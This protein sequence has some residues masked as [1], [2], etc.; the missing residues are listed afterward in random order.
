MSID[1]APFAYPVLRDDSAREAQ[2][3]ARVQGHTSGY[4]AGRREAAELLAADREQLLRDYEGQLEGARRAL[5]DATRA[6]N[7]AAA[8]FAS[9]AAPVLADADDAILTVAIE[10][11]EEIIGRELRDSAAWVGRVRDVLASVD[12]E[13][14]QGIRLNP[15]DAAALA[16]SAEPLRLPV[17]ADGTLARGDAVVLFADG[18]LDARVGSALERAR[19]AVEESR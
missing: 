4:T 7:S 9:L 17:T 11:A 8:R 10:L 3:R 14:P 6:L 12:D 13:G 16:E 15:A 2:E 19:T 1:F 5:A 18:M